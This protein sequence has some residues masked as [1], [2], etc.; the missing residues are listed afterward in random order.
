MA[1]LKM[2]CAIVGAAVLL[3]FFLEPADRGR[4]PVYYATMKSDLRNLIS[5][6][7]YV[8]RNTGR[9]APS[10]EAMG[11]TIYQASSGVVVTLQLVNDTMWVA[12][13]QHLSAPTVR[14]RIT[15]YSSE[16]RYTDADAD[17]PLCEPPLPPP[18]S[19]RW[20]WPWR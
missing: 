3:M 16:A 8:L 17:V 6:Q 18:G 2:L 9:F 13:A 7:D 4:V 5:A 20:R 1:L 10:L 11:D 14:C 19:L 12:E 15:S